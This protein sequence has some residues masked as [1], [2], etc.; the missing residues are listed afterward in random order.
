MIEVPP[1]FVD[2]DPLLLVLFFSSFRVLFLVWLEYLCSMTVTALA[3]GHAMLLYEPSWYFQICWR[4][5]TTW[6]SGFP[7]MFSFP[8]FLLVLMKEV[9]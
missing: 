9:L 1:D 4:G 7:S 6:C 5:S 2:G 8:A 3:G